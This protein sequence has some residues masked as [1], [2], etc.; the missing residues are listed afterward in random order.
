M[1]KRTSAFFALFV[2]LVAA[3]TA[4][5]ACAAGSDRV[6]VYPANHHYLMSA[7]GK[8]LLLIGYGNER[9][10]EPATLD[11]L[12]GKVNYV[13]AYFAVFIR[14]YGWNS[15]WQDQPWAVG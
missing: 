2:A 9:L 12:K 10:N 14:H 3:R 13:R 1:M 15:K 6:G 11:L 4:S 5:V 8:P 7:D